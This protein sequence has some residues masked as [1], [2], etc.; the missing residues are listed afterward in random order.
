[1]DN[2]TDTTEFFETAL[3]KKWPIPKTKPKFQLILSTSL[4]NALYDQADLACIRYHD[5]GMET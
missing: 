3:A 2:G 4:R 5:N 1:M